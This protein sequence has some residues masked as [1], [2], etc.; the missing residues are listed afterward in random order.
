MK[1]KPQDYEVTATK[2][3]IIDKIQKSL[4]SATVPADIET[5]SRAL[6]HIASV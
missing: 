2:K 4:E 6:V 3:L 1:G 5:L